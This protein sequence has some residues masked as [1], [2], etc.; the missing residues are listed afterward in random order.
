MDLTK[1]Q[2]DCSVP[3]KA[4]IMSG[5]AGLKTEILWTESKYEKSIIPYIRSWQLRPR[6][7][8]PLH[9]FLTLLNTEVKEVY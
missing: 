2:N 6:I 5:K 3:F 4:H 9:V 1:T 7:Y 8:F